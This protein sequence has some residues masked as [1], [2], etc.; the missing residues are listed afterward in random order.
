MKNHTPLPILRLVELGNVVFAR[1]VIE[2]E[3]FR[4]WIGEDFDLTGGILYACHNHAAIDAQ[5]ILRSHFE[6]VEP[7]QFVVPLVSL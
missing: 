1:L 2:D 3:Q 7:R 6:G 4:R 5:N